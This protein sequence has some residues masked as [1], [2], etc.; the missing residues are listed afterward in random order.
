[1][2]IAICDFLIAVREVSEVSGCGPF[3]S[4]E[5]SCNFCTFCDILSDGCDWVLSGLQSEM[6]LELGSNGNSNS[7]QNHVHHKLHCAGTSVGQTTRF[8]IKWTKSVARFWGRKFI[9]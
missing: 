2:R 3:P 8:T 7:K 5:G 4:S 1:M 9:K 6:E